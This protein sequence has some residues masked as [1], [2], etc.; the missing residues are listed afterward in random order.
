LL[1]VTRDHDGHETRHD[2]RDDEAELCGGHHSAAA[3]VPP[4]VRL[5]S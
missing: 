5:M 4:R 2:Q 1:R 3:V